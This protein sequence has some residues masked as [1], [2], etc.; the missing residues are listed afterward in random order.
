[1][2]LWTA[3]DKNTKQQLYLTQI[4]LD[5][6]WTDTVSVADFWCFPVY[7]FRRN[8]LTQRVNAKIGRTVAWKWNLRESPVMF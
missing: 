8:Q 1:M 2:H 3:C 6:Q 5:C 4:Y 7:W